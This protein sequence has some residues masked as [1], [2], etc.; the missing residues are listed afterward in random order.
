MEKPLK[1][2]IIEALM[3]NLEAQMITTPARP[4]VQ[5]RSIEW[6]RDPV[7]VS[8]AHP[9]LNFFD[10]PDV[11]VDSG[12][13]SLG[14]TRNVAMVARLILEAGERGAAEMVTLYTAEII[15]VLESDMQLGGLINQIFGISIEPF[16]DKVSVPICGA[17]IEFTLQYRIEWANPYAR[18][19]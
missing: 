11:E 16:F 13:T 4:D 12:N 3:A 2:Q 14:R 18:G 17:F 10:G 5:L 8:A 15:R 19:S 7:Q 1:Q 9:S 6:L